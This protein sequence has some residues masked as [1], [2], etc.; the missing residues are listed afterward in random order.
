[1]DM[2]GWNTGQCVHLQAGVGTGREEC[3]QARKVLG[4][5]SAVHCPCP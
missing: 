5:V 4:L 2:E 3:V 1:M